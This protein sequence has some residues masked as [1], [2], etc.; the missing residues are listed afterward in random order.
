MKV[1]SPEIMQ[2]AEKYLF[3]K[4]GVSPVSLMKEAA[5]GMY[6][7]IKD[8]LRP[9]DAVCVLCGKGNNAGDGYELARLMKQAGYNVV[10]IS[11]FDAPPSAEPAKT[12]FEQYISEGGGLENN[13]RA[14]AKIIAVSDIIIDAVFGIGF[15]GKIEPDSTM[16][17]LIDQANC[18]PR[19]YRIALD[20]PSGV[21][22]DDGSVGNIAFVADMTLTVKAVKTGMMSYPAKF[23]CGRTEI[24]SISIPDKLLDEY[25]NPCVIPDDKYVHSV[26]PKRPEMSNKGDFGKL[27]CVCGSGDMTGAAVLSAEAALRAG[28]GLV[29]LASERS[30]IDCVRNYLREPVY[31]PVCWDDSQSVHNLISGLSKYSAILVGCGLG[32]SAQKKQFLEYVIKNASARLI[33]DADGINMLSENINILKEARKTPIITPHP[34]EFSR[35]SGLEVSYINDN[36]IRCALEFAAKTRCITVLKGAGTITAAPDGRFA[37]NASGNAG[38]AKGGSGDV[39]AGL[40]SGLAANPA[41]G[42]FEAAASGVYLHGRAADVL[43]G[44]YSEYGFL[45]S[46]LAQE[47]AK[48]L[49]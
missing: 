42:A 32:K 4:K 22:S 17:K 38:L 10:C 48:M 29:T 20:V 18:A 31:T 13:P 12:C 27:L 7:L 23:F 21:R 30:V 28:T 8:R 25:E 41:I 46:E 9:F 49:P 14:A 5:H 16:Y 40:I 26:L 47:F 1:Y 39:L 2:S 6:E 15:K 44:K 34:A 36:R 37:I 45:P 24:V 35:I 3:D 33:I 19:A 43:K 11:V